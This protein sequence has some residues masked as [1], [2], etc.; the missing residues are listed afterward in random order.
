[1][2]K[3]NK[4]KQTTGNE[5]EGGRGISSWRLVRWGVD[6]Q[7]GTRGSRRVGMTSLL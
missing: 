5:P 6:E 3:N 1:M 4:N 7:S 2:P